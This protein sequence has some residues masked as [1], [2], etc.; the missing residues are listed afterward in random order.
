MRNRRF[1]LVPTSDD[2]DEAPPPPPPLPPPPPPPPRRAEVDQQPKQRKRKKAKLQ[3]DNEE[4][5]RSE[6]S[7]D[8][9]VQEDAKPIGDVVRV[10]GKGRGRRRHYEAFEYDGTRFDLVSILCFHFDC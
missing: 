1:A 5:S 8:D 6:G 2:E 4:E 7:K 9:G 3:D 10:S